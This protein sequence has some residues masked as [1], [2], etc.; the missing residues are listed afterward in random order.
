M[1]MNRQT[2]RIGTWLVA[3]MAMA[4]SMGACSEFIEEPLTDER[5][6][7][8]SPGAGAAAKSDTLSFF[9]DPVDHAL[10]YRLQVAAPAFGDAAL[11]YA[12]TTLEKENY[13]LFLPPG[14]YQWRV[15][16]LNGSSGT[17]YTT[18]SFTVIDADAGNQTE[19]VVP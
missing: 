5:V 12:D 3:T 19:T 13:R 6:V 18:R 1:L 2:N 4:W 14:N 17:R 11:F 7:L 8:L 10:Q 9:W 15:K 16:A